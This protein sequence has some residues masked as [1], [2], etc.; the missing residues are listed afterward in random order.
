MTLE[1][2]F[3]VSYRGC[4]SSSFWLVSEPVARRALVEVVSE[5][6]ARQKGA[7]MTPRRQCKAASSQVCCE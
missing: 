3:A 1:G 6:K 5:A 4:S 7:G 2:D